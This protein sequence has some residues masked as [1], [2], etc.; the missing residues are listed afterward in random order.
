MGEIEQE[1]VGKVAQFEAMPDE[2]KAAFA[3]VHNHLNL[4]SGAIDQNHDTIITQFLGQ[5]SISQLEKLQHAMGNTKVDY[6][7]QFLGK[8]VFSGGETTCRM[9]ETNCKLIKDM[10]LLVVKRGFFSQYMNE[11]AQTHIETFRSDV[12]KAMIDAGK[13]AGYA[14]AKAEAKAAAAPAPA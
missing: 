2:H 4:V 6:I 7:V 5:L 14:S 8:Q 9:M 13:I 10:M 12:T 3:V 1:L 11:N